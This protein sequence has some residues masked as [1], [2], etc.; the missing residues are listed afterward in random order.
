MCS[1]CCV[2]LGQCN[3]KTEGGALRI[4]GE[5]LRD[6]GA[7]AKCVER[8]LVEWPTGCEVNRSNLERGLELGL[9]VRW[10]IA[11]FT[12]KNDPARR[13]YDETLVQW[14]NSLIDTLDS[15]TRAND[16]G[17][18]HHAF[19]TSGM[20]VYREAFLVAVLCL[21]E[22]LERRGVTLEGDCLGRP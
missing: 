17:Q 15:A 11:V 7:D 13:T 3:H 21:V 9:N 18:A 6:K 10:A 2:A 19:M 1:L 14:R 20:L 5:M 12:D 4:T 8:F 22:D 16:G